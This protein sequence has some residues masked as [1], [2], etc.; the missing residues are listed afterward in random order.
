MAKITSASFVLC[1]VSRTAFL[2]ALLLCKGQQSDL[3]GAVIVLCKGKSAVKLGAFSLGKGNGDAAVLDLVGALGGAYLI[4]C[5]EGADGQ[6]ASGE[7]NGGVRAEKLGS[8]VGAGEG[9]S[10]CA[11]QAECERDGK[12]RRKNSF[13][14]HCHSPFL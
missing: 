13:C 4:T 2:G 7:G 10:A 14:F 3:D 11:E 12:C 6:L 5:K 9:V 1:C 8:L